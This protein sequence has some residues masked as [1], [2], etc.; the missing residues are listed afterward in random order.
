MSRP[1]LL[2]CGKRE[3]SAA[4]ICYLPRSSPAVALETGRIVGQVACGKF[5]IMSRDAEQRANDLVDNDDEDEDVPRLF[6]H[7]D[8]EHED[9][10]VLQRAFGCLLRESEEDLRY[11]GVDALDSSLPLAQAGD[12][13]GVSVDVDQYITTL[14]EKNGISLMVNDTIDKLGD[15]GEFLFLVLEDDHSQGLDHHLDQCGS[16]AA[17]AATAVSAAE[18]EEEAAW[19]VAHA[20]AVGGIVQPPPV[21]TMAAAAVAAVAAATGAAATG[22]L[23]AMPNDI[24]VRCLRH[25]QPQSLGSAASACWTLRAAAED[26]AGLRAA[27]SAW[28]TRHVDVDEALHAGFGRAAL[29]FAA[30]AGCLGLADEPPEADYPA[31]GECIEEILKGNLERT[32]GA[33]LR[34]GDSR[35]CADGSVTIVAD[36]VVTVLRK[37]GRPLYGYESASAG[38]WCAQ[39]RAVLKQ[40]HPDTIMS[41]TAFAVV[42]DLR[43]AAR[44]DWRARREFDVAFLCQQFGRVAASA[45]R[46]HGRDHVRSARR[47]REPDRR[48]RRHRRAPC[49]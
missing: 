13:N 43:C 48:R 12:A 28:R 15:D 20:R 44:S 39:Q 40:V 1:N 31:V 37:L 24:V 27:R 10:T 14:R 46:G 23:F 3:A 41:T 25:L 45:A 4:Q 42:G 7:P 18:D 38:L 16:G 2:Q 21:A 8:T 19:C 33:V 29:D 49:R 22:N 36:D 30:R 34:R 5:G 47:L 26:G 6:D 35:K 9:F 17:L 11:V 32:L